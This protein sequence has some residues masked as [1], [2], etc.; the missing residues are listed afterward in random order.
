M[1]EQDK[2]LAHEESRA[3]NM[4][5]N[6][7]KSSNQ[8]KILSV[9]G[10]VYISLIIWF[11]YL[12]FTAFWDAGD[13][14]GTGEK[15]LPGLASGFFLGRKRVSNCCQCRVNVSLSRYGHVV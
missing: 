15:P 12:V 14:Y 4:S 13:A 8:L 10:L 11:H 3:V 2:L 7:D 9:E 5:K 1:D 6:V